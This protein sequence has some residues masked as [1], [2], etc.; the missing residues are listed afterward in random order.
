M[1]DYPAPYIENK[2]ERKK[3]HWIRNIIKL[4]PKLLPDGTVHRPIVNTLKCSECGIETAIQE[5][6]WLK[7]KF[8][9]YCGSENEEEP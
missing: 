5:G 6:R 2:P 4:E 1:L 7:F 8:C 9:P 3:G